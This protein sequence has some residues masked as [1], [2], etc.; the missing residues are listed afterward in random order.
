MKH[1]F[2]SLTFVL[3]FIFS[4]A[5][6]QAQE[7]VSSH[8]FKV[9]HILGCIE[10]HYP[11]EAAKMQTYTDTHNVTIIKQ[12]GGLVGGVQYVADM[13]DA[14]RDGKTHAVE[15]I[16]SAGYIEQAGST[17]ANKKYS[18]DFT[19]RR[20]AMIKICIKPGLQTN[21][22]KMTFDA[23]SKPPKFSIRTKP[24]KPA[25]QLI[26]QKTADLIDQDNNKFKAQAAEAVKKLLSEIKSRQR[27]LKPQELG[28]LWD[29][30]G[31]AEVVKVTFSGET[32]QTKV[33]MKQVSD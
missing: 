33:R 3:C 9:K 29:E 18:R 5:H 7:E 27:K 17:G 25:N 21:G 14:S 6:L 28:K 11:G 23:K 10:L 4:S 31:L 20:A 19:V 2:A 24:G 12:G 26:T 1:L 13:E 32:Y 30:E 15:E 16:A 22:L 8:A